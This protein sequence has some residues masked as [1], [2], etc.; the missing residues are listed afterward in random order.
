MKSSK[1]YSGLI[2]GFRR[3]LWHLHNPLIDNSDSCKL[4]FT[5]P[6]LT[7][8]KTPWGNLLLQSLLFCCVLFCWSKNCTL[9]KCYLQD[10]IFPCSYIGSTE[11]RTKTHGYGLWEALV[12]LIR[13][14]SVGL[15]ALF[16]ACFHLQVCDKYLLLH[17][18]NFF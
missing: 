11:Y 13:L 1:E 4:L 18:L 16:C 14:D 5:K 7:V 6:F 15:G 10:Y 17:M 3:H 12:P 8:I 9:Q 2:W